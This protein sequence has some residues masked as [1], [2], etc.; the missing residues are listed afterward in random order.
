MYSRLK[1]AKK[2]VN[3][4]ISKGGK[5]ADKLVIDQ[6]DLVIRKITQRNTI[7]NWEPSSITTGSCGYYVLIK[8]FVKDIENVPLISRYV[9]IYITLHTI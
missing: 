5:P 1:E 8:Y 2:C 7:K 9:S 6:M 3:L 4:A